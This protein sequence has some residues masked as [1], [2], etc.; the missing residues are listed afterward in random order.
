MSVTALGQ[1]IIII[2]S[3]DIMQELDKKGA[4]YSDRPRLEM[5]GELVGYNETLVLIPYGERF[6][7]YRKDIAKTIGGTAQMREFHHLIET[8][9]QRFLQRTL[10]K[11]DDLMSHL[12]KLQGNVILKLTYGIDVQDGDDPYVALIERANVNFNKAT[13][14]GSFLVDFFP[15]LRSL[16]EWLPGMGFMETARRWRK[17]T[18]EMVEAPYQFTLQQMEAGTAPKSYVSSI[19]E[20]SKLD[21]DGIRDLKF[22]ASSLYGGGADTTVSAEYAFYLAMVLFPVLTAYSIVDVQKKAQAEIDSVV[23]R[24]R[25]PRHEDVARLPYVNAVVT[26][27]LR[28]NNVAPTGVPHRAMEDGIVAGYFIPK[29][30]IVLCNFWQMMHDEK[31]WPEPFEFLPERYLG[32]NPQ[33]NPREFC[34]GFGR[35]ICPGMYLAQAALAMTVA[36]TL[37][38][39]NVTNALDE[40]GVPIVPKHENTSGTISYPE[41]FKCKIEPRSERAASLIMEEIH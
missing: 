6:R 12:R 9:S 16:P 24:D 26:E 7:R 38:V 17:D 20:E 41:P 32:P 21:A 27:V 15:I 1:P 11:P 4:I 40:N 14:P 10:A 3:L 23:G 18:V 2:N 28:W 36:M 13:I 34:F 31:M 5:G 35:R 25:L 19:L 37:A 39:F 8:S 29:D 22:S 33:P 30:A